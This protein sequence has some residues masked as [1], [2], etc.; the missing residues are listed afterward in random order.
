MKHLKCVKDHGVAQP[1]LGV[2]LV[3]PRLLVLEIAM[4]E[5]FRECIHSVARIAYQRASFLASAFHH[6]LQISH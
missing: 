2:D 6:S 3:M 4:A 1:I 5:S